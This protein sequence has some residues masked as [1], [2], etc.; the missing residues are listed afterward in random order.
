MLVD[1]WLVLEGLHGHAPAAPGPQRCLR[2]KVHGRPGGQH[3]P[4]AAQH[5]GHQLL[6]GCSLSLRQCLRVLGS[7]SRLVLGG[8]STGRGRS[9]AWAAPKAPQ[10]LLLQ[11]Q[12]LVLQDALPLSSREA[13]LR[14]GASRPWLRELPGLG[15]GLRSVRVGTTF[16]RVGA[17]AEVLRAAGRPGRAGAAGRHRAR[18]HGGLVA[19][20]L[21]RRILGVVGILCGARHRRRAVL[22]AVALQAALRRGALALDHVDR[23]GPQQRGADVG[24]PLRTQRRLRPQLLQPPPLSRQRAVLLYAG[25]LLCGDLRRSSGLHDRR[26]STLLLLPEQLLLLPLLRQKPVALDAGPLLVREPWAGLQGRRLLGT[27]ASDTDRF[28]MFSSAIF[29]TTVAI[30]VE[31]TALWRRR[32]AS[33]P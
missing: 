12:L 27:G 22:G 19:G 20:A 25:P 8:P 14:L 16:F 15:C 4:P 7:R 26:S 33:S 18:A 11:R 2:V 30:R 1:L 3:V 28:H 9:H 10:A 32:A 31:A 13:K 5:L 24:L 6:L 29:S 23:H 21:C 17:R